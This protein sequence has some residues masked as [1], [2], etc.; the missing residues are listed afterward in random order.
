MNKEKNSIILLIYVNYRVED[1]NLL[2]LNSMKSARCKNHVDGNIC[3]SKR[4]LDGAYLDSLQ[5]VYC[6]LLNT[7][8]GGY[9]IAEIL[10]ANLFVYLYILVPKEKTLQFFTF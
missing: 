7:A 3:T 1:I 6:I 8:P 5:G 4:A 2:L 10:D 9:G